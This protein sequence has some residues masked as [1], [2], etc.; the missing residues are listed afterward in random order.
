[1]GFLLNRKK[2]TTEKRQTT[3]LWESAPC[4]SPSR[5]P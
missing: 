2:T 4:P 1:M 5:N 3:E